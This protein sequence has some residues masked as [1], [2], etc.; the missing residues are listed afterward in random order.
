VSVP[1][2]EYVRALDTALETP[3]ADPAVRHPTSNDAEALAQLML[4][5]Y[6]GTIDD[7]GETIVEAREEVAR[8]LAGRPLLEHS[9]LRLEDDQPV[10]ACLVAWST[11]EC[12]MVAYAMT[13]AGWKNRGLASAL[14]ALSLRSLTDAG[15]DQ[16]RAWITEG[17]TPSETVFLRAGFRRV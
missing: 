6:H 13:A 12:P 7:E 14:V 3:A 4:D 11:R 2:H 15:H 10:S 1:R 8:Y 17:N 9:W 16:V 5:S